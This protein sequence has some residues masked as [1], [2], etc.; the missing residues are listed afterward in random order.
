VKNTGM[1]QIFKDG[2]ENIS[3]VFLRVSNI[4]QKTFVE[5]NEVGTEAAAVT[6]I[7]MDTTGHFG[8]YPFFANRPFL[9]LIKENSTGSIMFIGRMDEPEE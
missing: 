5:V 8:D 3:D 6:I 7:E 4:K 1:T 9:Y 2:F